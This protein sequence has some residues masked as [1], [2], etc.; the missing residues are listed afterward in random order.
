MSSL[1]LTPPSSAPL[2]NVPSLLV[3]VVSPVAIT[4]QQWTFGWLWQVDRVKEQVQVY[5]TDFPG[6]DNLETLVLTSYMTFK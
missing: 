5:S 1:P 6:L 3:P 4:G 2:S